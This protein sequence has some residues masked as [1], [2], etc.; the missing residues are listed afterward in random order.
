MMWGIRTTVPNIARFA[1]SVVRRGRCIDLLRVYGIVRGSKRCSLADDRR[2][3]DGAICE[4]TDFKPGVEMG[5]WCREEAQKVR[6]SLR[7][8]GLVHQSR[9]KF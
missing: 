2:R 7:F 4:A 8:C 9:L 3:G 6:L 5:G 1:P